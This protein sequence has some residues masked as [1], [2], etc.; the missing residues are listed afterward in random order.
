MGDGAKTRRLYE[1]AVE[2][3][4]RNT[5]ALRELVGPALWDAPFAVVR[6]ETPS[7][8]AWRQAVRA[9][10]DAAEAAGI[11]DGI[12]LR[13]TMGVGDWPGG[14]TPRS[15]GWVC[16]GGRC[17]RVELRE[18]ASPQTPACLLAGQP[19]RLVGG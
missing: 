6:D 14:P 7:T 3:V 16:P 4:C 8:D 5:D 13:A 18:G 19:M 17:A 12:G 9:L 11:P 2:Y 1:D 10:H 15:A